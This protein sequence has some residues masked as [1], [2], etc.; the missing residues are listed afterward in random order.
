MITV[1]Y[2]HKI[3]FPKKRCYD[4]VVTFMY[5]DAEYFTT[6][7][8][9]F[10]QAIDADN[11]VRALR[12]V[13]KYNDIFT[14]P[15]IARY[16]L[17]DYYAEWLEQD[18]SIDTWDQHIEKVDQDVLQNSETFWGKVDT[19]SDKYP[20]ICDI[21]IIYYDEDGYGWKSKWHE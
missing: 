9:S 20:S 7:S 17:A 21:T 19:F 16:I 6:N 13:K 14:N 2:S 15:S 5:G 11:F 10:N 1:D 4:V 12:A 8:R 3:V 18:D